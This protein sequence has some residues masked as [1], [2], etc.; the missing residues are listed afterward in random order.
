MVGIILMVHCDGS[1]AESRVI[2]PEE[3]QLLC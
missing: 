2:D 3:F 1:D